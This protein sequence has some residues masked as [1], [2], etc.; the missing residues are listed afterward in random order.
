MEN[1]TQSLNRETSLALSYTGRVFTTPIVSLN[2]P[3]GVM[4]RD[5]V[6]RI[7]NNRCFQEEAYIS[8]W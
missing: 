7:K 3:E 6:K 2:I 1:N 8:L 5:Y 4:F